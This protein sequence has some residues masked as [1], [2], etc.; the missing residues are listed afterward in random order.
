MLMLAKILPKTTLYQSLIL[1]S[2]NTP[3]PVSLALN[4]L[5]GNRGQAI[6]PLRPSGT[7]RF[8]G[9]PVDVV[10]QGDFIEA[11]QA[12][13]VIHVEGTRVVV[14]PVSNDSNA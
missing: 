4:P 8:D 3:L 6:T 7:A 1:H 10:T 11:G 2:T 9:E 12:V 14:A 5:I 13:E